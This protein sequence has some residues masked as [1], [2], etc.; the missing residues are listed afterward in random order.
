[1]KCLA[2]WWAVVIGLTAFFAV[3]P[4]HAQTP[5]RRPGLWGSVSS[6]RLTMPLNSLGL[7]FGPNQ[8]AMFGQRYGDNAPD[9]G[10]AFE[11]PTSG[12]QDQ[13]WIRG[14]VV[15][16]LSPQLEAGALFLTFRAT[17]DFHYSNFPV[18]ITYSWTFDN[19][20]IGAKLSFMTPVEVKSWSFNPGAPVVI[21]LK[22]ARI[23]TGVFLPLLT[24]ENPSIG[25]NIPLRGTYNLTPR[26]FVGAETGVYEAAFGTGNGLSS[27]LGA[28]VG[29]TTY[30]G[31]RIIDFSARFNWNE[32][33][34]YAPS[35]S[36]DVVN[37]G[38]YQLFA[39]ATFY[40]KV[41]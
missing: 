8:T 27:P 6:R 22:H 4:A 14:G 41:M 39:G 21:R 7:I 17:P 3:D 28:L 35:D 20:D 19:V 34:R 16:G 5:E 37:V 1:M 9:G 38:A 18:Y 33:L 24:E 15:F 13:L 26:W 10:L 31:S 25:L 29:Y 32:F 23:D 12:A 2:Y 30:L 40:S 36:E 11:S